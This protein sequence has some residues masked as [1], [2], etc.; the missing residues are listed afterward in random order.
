MIKFI[1]YC[2]FIL[3]LGCFIS[4]NDPAFIDTDLVDVDLLDI[5]IE[6]DFEITA[7][8][9]PE[10]SILTYAP[11]QVLVARYP[12]GIA[13]DPVFGTST[14]TTVMQFFLT[15]TSPPTFTGAVVDSVIMELVFN[16]DNP[17]YGDTTGVLGLEVFELA[18]TLDA[19][20]DFYSNFSVQ[21]ATESIGSYEGVPNF[22]D[23]SA[24]FRIQGDTLFRDTFPAHIRFPLMNS[25]GERVINA[26]N[27]VLTSTTNFISTFQGLEIRPTN[28]TEGLVA[29]DL[30][31]FSSGRGVTT[32][33]ASVLIY[34]TIDGVQRQYNLAI[35]PGFSVK[36]PRYEQDYVGST[37]GEFINDEAKGDSLLFVQG[38]NGANAVVRLE[39][40][41]TLAGSIING[42]TLEVYGTALNSNEDIRPLPSQLVL[43]SFDDDGV[44]SYI[45]DFQS[46]SLV[47]TLSLSGGEPEDIGNGIYKYTFNVASELQDIIDGNGSNEIYIRVNSKIATMNRAVLFGADHS[48]YPIKLNVTYTKL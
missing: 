39:G 46:A 33:G 17:H 25:F 7:F 31:S 38:M 20:S 40:L 11:R 47:G 35:Q 16:P 29:F 32:S 37:V 8:T 21:T 42:A 14:A 10:D 5:Q 4:C 27:D 2:F 28:E 1:Y 23:S 9:V 12:F 45:R 34:Y 44:L 15:N 43:R 48:T 22:R 26:G 36:F 41:D 30:D 19:A 13:T 18:E 3:A 24:T 6:D